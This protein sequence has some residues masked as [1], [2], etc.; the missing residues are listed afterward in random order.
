MKGLYLVHG[1]VSLFS[2]HND[3]GNQYAPN[4]SADKTP[5]GDPWYAG[6]GEIGASYPFEKKWGTMRFRTD[7]AVVSYQGMW[8]VQGMVGGEIQFRT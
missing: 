3:R 4:K 7:L 2:A 1:E 6:Y 8:D 5:T